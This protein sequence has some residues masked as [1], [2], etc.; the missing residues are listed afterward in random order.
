M[1][2]QNYE[3]GFDQSKGRG[4][5]D[6]FFNLLSLITVGWMSIA[7][8]MILFQIINKFFATKAIDYVAMFS[9][10]PLKFGIASAII[11]TPI[12]L[13]VSGLLHRYYKTGKLNHQSGIHKWLTYL[14]LLV[15]ALTVIGRLIY[16]LFRFLD[17]DY[18]IAVILKTLVMLV[19][20]GGIF[21][22]Y[23]YDLMRKDFSQK[24]L[25]SKVSM[26]LVIII[27]LASVIGGFMI[28]DSPATARAV[29]FDQQRT[30]DLYNL[31]GMINDYYS[32]NKKLPQDLSAEK[33][34]Q[35]Q[36]PETNKVY[37]YKITGEK[38]YEL[39]ATFSLAYNPNRSEYNY[40][41][42][43]DWSYHQAGYQCFKSVAVDYST[44]K[45]EAAP[46][47][48]EASVQ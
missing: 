38:E 40:G 39:C 6:A 35:Y 23:L 20:A 42:N 47:P 37:D 24:S 1:E 10:G 44:I 26:T 33:F 29:K 25:I 41:G 8:G 43:K 18:A 3:S 31:E 19:I 22:Y 27:A 4:A 36:D 28:I 7:L 45:G 11:L 15:S 46:M 12:F 17:G 9:Q 34:S 16:Q 13:A 2:K 30:N 32:Q 5:L 21:G 48:I 14:M